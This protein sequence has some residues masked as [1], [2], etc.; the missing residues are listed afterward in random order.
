MFQAENIIHGETRRFDLPQ[1]GRSVV[2]ER[3]VT[4]GIGRNVDLS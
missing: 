2:E 4:F 3:Q 1:K